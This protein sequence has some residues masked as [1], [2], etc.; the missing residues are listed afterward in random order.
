MW[1]VFPTGKKK[2]CLS[3][4]P[5]TKEMLEL[6]TANIQGAF[7]YKATSKHRANPHGNVVHSVTRLHILRS[8]VQPA[9]VF[10]QRA[11]VFLSGNPDSVDV[12]L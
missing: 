11:G 9:A 6:P 4:A 1:R 5:D 10:P 12:E 8:A 7:I 3:L 2:S